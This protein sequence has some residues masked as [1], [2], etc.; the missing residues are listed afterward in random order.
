MTA[1]AD[2]SRTEVCDVIVVGAGTAAFEAAVAAAEAGATRVVL[3]EKAPERHFGGNGRFSHTGFRWAYSGPDEIR[4]FVPQVPEE[5]FQAMELPGY[6]ADEFLADLNRVTH[7]RIQPD[8]ARTLVDQS[9]SAVH[10][11]LELGI[12]WE[13]EAGVEIDGRR[14]FEPGGVIHPS[15]GMKAGLSQLLQ[16]REIAERFHVQVR[17]DAAVFALLGDPRRVRGVRVSTPAGTYKLHAPATILCSG[18]FQANKALRAQYLGPNADL[19]KVR[20]SRYD[21]GEVLRLAIDMGA[22]P[23]GHWQEAHTAPIDAGFPDVEQSNRAN[24]YSYPF[25]ITVN[26]LGQRF[27]DEAESFIAYTY[28][29]TGRVVLAQPGAIAYQIYDKRG[30]ELL[31]RRHYDNA[32]PIEATSIAE[33]A[34]KL[35]IASGLL[36]KTVAD[37]N[38]AI[39]DTVPFDPAKL[40]GRSTIGLTPPKSNWSIAIEQPPFVAYAV[41]GGITFTFGGLQIDT[42]ARVLNTADEPIDGL[43]ASGDILGLFY[44]N[45]PSFTGQTRNAVFSRLAGQGAARL[46]AGLHA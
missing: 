27:F 46:A 23:A 44:H 31:W 30:S 2:D 36:E 12:T 38:A 16:W 42:E 45:Y 43:F 5:Q 25:G 37:F 33:L 21:T 22:K 20:G 41:T 26:T 19:M 6:T 10:W 11:M 14:H 9:N 8:L 32:E 28:A 4:E 13:P 7:G 3:L 15:G 40:D 1:A 17:Y 39:D 35:G 34:N 29:K 24:R 18:G